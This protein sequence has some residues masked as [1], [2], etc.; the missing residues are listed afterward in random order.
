[1]S[2]TSFLDIRSKTTLPEGVVLP[3]SAQKGWGLDLLRSILR[4]SRTQLDNAQSKYLYLTSQDSDRGPIYSPLGSVKSSDRLP[5]GRTLESVFKRTSRGYQRL[6]SGRDRIVALN[7]SKLRNVSIK[8][9][10]PH[11]LIEFLEK[12]TSDKIQVCV[13]DE[14]MWVCL[15]EIFGASRVTRVPKCTH[16]MI[17]EGVV[18]VLG[19]SKAVEL[20][21][22]PFRLKIC[23]HSV[24]DLMNVLEEVLPQV[25][26]QEL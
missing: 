10:R 7:D 20:S 18:L 11:S 4:L 26:A 14:S 22:N 15:E 3:I 8:N 2:V 25:K 6:D 21:L 17:R 16:D 13:K 12:K 23:A 5:G 1:M 19:Q 24:L 9:Y